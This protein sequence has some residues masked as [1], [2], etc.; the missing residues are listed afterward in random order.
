[1][2]F[3]THQD[4]LLLVLF[5]H[6][7]Q[8]TLLTGVVTSNINIFDYALSIFR[9]LIH[10]KKKNSTAT[11]FAKNAIKKLQQHSLG[12]EEVEALYQVAKYGWGNL[13]NGNQLIGEL[14]NQLQHSQ[15]KTSKKRKLIEQ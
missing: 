10:Q 14:L 15:R 3:S 7:F 4:S 9:S 13:I 5:K 1:M 12:V 6:Q 8:F 11:K 2:F